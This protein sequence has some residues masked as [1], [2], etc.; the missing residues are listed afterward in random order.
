MVTHP[1]GK[2]RVSGLT[3]Q[4]NLVQLD[5]L[6]RTPPRIRPLG[7]RDRRVAIFAC[8]TGQNLVPR[9]TLKARL[10]DRETMV[11]AKYLSDRHG[12]MSTPQTAQSGLISSELPSI[13]PDPR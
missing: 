1:T 2:R 8:P 10:I 3:L 7:D 11:A 5:A 12:H 4:G 9:L 13:S 6:A